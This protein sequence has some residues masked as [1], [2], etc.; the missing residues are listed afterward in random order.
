MFTT[1]TDMFS[2]ISDDGCSWNGQVPSD[3]EAAKAALLA[4]E[5]REKA[6]YKYEVIEE[7]MDR[8]RQERRGRRAKEKAQRE[9]RY[10][11]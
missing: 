8:D 3:S 2:N 11:G 10:P 9:R 5:R 1:A 7:M 6:G 4:C